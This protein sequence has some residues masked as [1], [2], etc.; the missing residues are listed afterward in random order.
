MSRP[1]RIAFFVHE[2]PAISE[3]FVL[4]QITGLLD[5]GHDVTIFAVCPRPEALVHEDVERYGLRARTRY[6][7][8]PDGA[9]IR[10]ARGFAA[11][12]HHGWTH[13]R[14]FFRA[15]NVRR[16]GRDATSLRLLFW[17]LC[18]R[19]EK[20]FD[21]I[22]C[23]FG[24]IGQLTAK[25]RDI[26]AIE[27]RLV[28]AFH[29]VDISAYVRDKRDYYDFLFATGDLFQPIS[30][31]WSRKLV[32][33]GC[34]PA[35]IEIHHMGIDSTRYPFRPRRYEADRPLRVLTVG[36][37]VEK[38]GI[39]DG[40]RAVAEVI[41]QGIPVHYLV[42]GDG[43]LRGELER[44][45]RDLKIEAQV[46]FGGW[47]DQ[48]AVAQLMAENDVLLAPSVTSSDGDQE[49]IPVTIMEAMA[50]GMLVVSTEH[51]GI[52]ELVEHARSGLLVPERD[53]MA[54]TG[55][56]LRLVRS[57][58]LWPAMCAAAREAVRRE[59]EIATLNDRLVDRYQLLLDQA[60]PGIDRAMFAA[61]GR[62][63]TN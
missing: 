8:M 23:H 48:A 30:R 60:R 3:T 19:D 4:N 43:P 42:I 59:F 56:L 13:L 62:F 26:G 9:G 12:L 49:G 17:A 11:M 2:F 55:A 29:G 47:R 41:N 5:R 40:L 46:E 53:V 16:Y 51:S 15:L 35:R 27:G 10:I 14:I 33:L 34:D 45:V 7:N 39:A 20:S 6:L 50:A 63:A 58:D 54:L 37:M 52:P 24:P 36:R 31:A 38:K 28:T 1:L 21:V 22:Q 44:L 32:E 61:R 18:L 57:P 25:L